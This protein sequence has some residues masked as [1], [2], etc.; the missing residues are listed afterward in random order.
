MEY[1]MK[2]PDVFDSSY[3]NYPGEANFTALSAKLHLEPFPTNLAPPR[4]FPSLDDATALADSIVLQTSRVDPLQQD[5][6]SREAPSPLEVFPAYDLQSS[7]SWSLSGG[8]TDINYLSPLHKSTASNT[9][10]S[11]ELNPPSDDAMAA[12]QCDFKGCDRVCKDHKS[13]QYVIL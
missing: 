1:V 12:V 4:T 2:C 3:A 5:G 11:E 9:T 7:S 10:S 8:L 6:L 13:L